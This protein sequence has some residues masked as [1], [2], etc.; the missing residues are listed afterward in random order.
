M[1]AKTTHILKNG[2][3]FDALFPR[4]IFSETTVKKNA[5]V[6]D[7]VRFIPKVVS[8]TQWQVEK[9][10]E[11]ELKYLSLNEACKKLWHFVKD[12]IAYKE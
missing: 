1:E 11:Q 12:H 9:F 6:E 7:T 3:Q 5:M 10:V 4:A 2:L 8:K